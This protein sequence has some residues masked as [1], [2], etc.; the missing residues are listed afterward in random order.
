MRRNALPGFVA[1]LVILVMGTN[2][3]VAQGRDIFSVSGVVVDARADNEFAAKSSGIAQGETDAFRTLLQRLTLNRDHNRLPYLDGKAVTALVR[4]FSVDREKFG[5]GRY[6][7]T[8]TVR[9]KAEA[10]R[11]LL[12][13]AYIPFA[14]T[15]SRP[16]LVLP[17]FQTAGITVLWEGTNPWFAAWSR[18]GPRNGLQPLLLPIGDLSDVADISAEEAILGERSKLSEIAGRYG[19]AETMVVVASL[20]GDQTFGLLRVEV[21]TSRFGKNGNG[22]TM[23]KRFVAKADPS[24][25]ALLDQAAK[26]VALEA[27]DSWKQKNILETDVKQYIV[28]RIPIEN[29]GD[30]LSIRKSLGGI[31]AIKKKRVLRISVHRVEVELAYIGSTDKL[32]LAM[33]QIDL[34]L[35]SGA[36]KS[37]WTLTFGAGG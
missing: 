3:L 31:A 21:A 16:V 4:D 32:R 13:D 24:R 14:E 28:V 10:V 18:L 33:A 1:V 15:A 11:K 29:L 17:V 37:V 27:E 30:W 19:A 20:T 25:D 2:N 34:D 8:L 6:I 5:G 36:D 22:Q 7:A 9:F 23:F 12:R 35:K 26:S